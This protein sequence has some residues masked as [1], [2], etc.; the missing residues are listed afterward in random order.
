MRRTRQKAARPHIYAIYSNAPALRPY[1]GDHIS[2]LET[3]RWMSRDCDVF[4]NNVLFDPKGNHAGVPG[5]DIVH[6]ESGY[7]LVYVRDNIEVLRAAKEA[8]LKTIYFGRTESADV[9]AYA[10][11]IAVHNKREADIIQGRMNEARTILIEQ[12]GRDGFSPMQ[13]TRRAEEFAKRWGAGFTLGFFGRIDNECFPSTFYSAK[14]I[15]EHYIP[16]L[17]VVF[18]GKLRWKFVLPQDLLHEEKYFEPV[19][20]PYVLSA[21]AATIG[22]EQPEAEHAGSNRT[23]ECVRCGVPIITRPYAARRD[24]LGE[25][26]P[27]FFS[28]V[29]ELVEK[30]V[31]LRYDVRFRTQVQDH[32]EA[33]RPRFAQS[34]I[35]ARNSKRLMSWLAPRDLGRQAAPPKL[36]PTG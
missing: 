36:K 3:L 27:L 22:I 18:A 12:P 33:L 13:G 17:N 23:I 26:Y 31:A 29:N 32:L 6:P 25:D 24:Q 7:D 30:V 14:D 4:Y 1:G 34:V 8:G 16:D 15:L 21:C 5:G 28:D 9:F 10:D 20:M 35:Q 19:D 11:M 2:E